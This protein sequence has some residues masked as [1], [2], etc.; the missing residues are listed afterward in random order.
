MNVL[1]RL[2]V[3][4]LLGFAFGVQAT[5]DGLRVNHIQVVGT[6]NSYHLRPEEPI[7][8]QIKA[9]R[10]DS[11]AAIDCSLPPL[12]VQMEHGVR[13]FELDCFRGENGFDVYHYPVYDQETTCATFKDCLDVML[14]WSM[15]NPD[16]VPVMVLVETKNEDIT[17][18]ELDQLDAEL[19]SVIPRE[20]LLTPDDVRGGME[21]LEQAI[22]EQGWPLLEESRGKFIFALHTRMS[23][24]DDYAEGRP[25]LQGRPMFATTE[26]GRPDAAVLV[27][28]GPVDGGDEI[29]RLVELGYFVRTRADSGIREP[30]ENDTTRREAAFASGANVI[31]TDFP[32]GSPHPDTGYVVEIPGGGAVRCNP[33]SA[34]GECD[35]EALEAND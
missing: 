14:G 26:E 2:S 7:W 15:S 3:L 17:P 1:F 5:N 30:R 28:N 4:M 22:L 34:P 19:L 21:T 24:M 16:H 9:A 8:S 13:S 18:E 25:S 10:P 6:H 29:R 23:T 27:K 32:M 11:A 20:K 33:V 35:S 31:S 12:N